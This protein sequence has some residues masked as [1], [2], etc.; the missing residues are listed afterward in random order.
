[1]SQLVSCL[2]PAG[3]TLSDVVD[4]TDGV[5]DWIVIPDDWKAANITFLIG[6]TAAGP[7]YSAVDFTGAH[8][9]IIAAQPGKAIGLRHDWH[10]SGYFVKFELNWAQDHDCTINFVLQKP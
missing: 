9:A 1:M 5:V 4:L 10:L 2:V 7:F 6:F 8:E 3:Q